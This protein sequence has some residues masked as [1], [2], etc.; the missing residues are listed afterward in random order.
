MAPGVESAVAV[1]EVTVLK[2]VV[3]SLSN[4]VAEQADRIKEL[5]GELQ[6]MRNGLF[7]R[8]RE[9][10]H[11]DQLQ[12]FEGDV[13]LTVETEEVELPAR[14]VT[15]KKKGHGRGQ[16]P[17]HLPREEIRLDLP[18]GERCCPFLQAYFVRR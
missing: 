11:P 8:R 9:S 15:R 1:D 13:A 17:A 6:I 16:F 12:L 14:T 4:Q 5:L 2:E 3:D 18:E 10:I 7:G